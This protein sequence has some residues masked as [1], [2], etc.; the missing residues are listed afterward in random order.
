MAHEEYIRILENSDT[1]VLFIHGIAGTPDHFRDFLPLVPE[2]WSVCNIL[3]DGHGKGV[4]DFSRTSMAKWKKQVDD[5]VSALLTT[6]RRIIIAAHSM[7]TLFA[8]R[9]AVEHPDDIAA[10]FLLAAPLK[11]L[12]K[13]RMAVNSAKVFFGNIKP[14]DH[15]AIAAQ[16]AY[17]IERDLRFWRYL[18]WI[19]RYLELFSEIRRTRRI[20]DSIRVPGCVYQSKNDEMVSLSAC[21]LLRRNA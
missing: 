16:R 8:M 19:P 7:G 17:G 15:M 9:Q 18:G 10:L 21:R 20:V 12:P 11:V 1:A 14:D 2:A 6:H 5:T 13:P 3:L 4:R